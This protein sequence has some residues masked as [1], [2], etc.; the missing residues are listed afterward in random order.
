MYN[1]VLIAL[2]AYE[3]AVA[4]A[5]CE[6]GDLVTYTRQAERET[7]TI[8]FPGNTFVRNITMTSLSH[9]PGASVGAREGGRDLAFSPLESNY[10]SNITSWNR[11]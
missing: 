6:V 8:K 5:R 10:A 3:V 7:L 2:F 11:R 1:P 9:H 4:A